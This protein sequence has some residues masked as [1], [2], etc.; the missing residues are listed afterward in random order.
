MGRDLVKVDGF[1]AGADECI[2]CFDEVLM[3]VL[4]QVL[5]TQELF[6]Y[7]MHGGNAVCGNEI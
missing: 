5:W 7:L 4:F 1:G 3:F 2:Y 6:A